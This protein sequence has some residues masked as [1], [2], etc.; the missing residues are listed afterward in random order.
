[1]LNSYDI[2]IDKRTRKYN[3]IRLP[4]KSCKV[5]KRKIS[6]LTFF[7]ERVSFFTLLLSLLK[8]Y[9]SMRYVVLINEI[10]SI[11]HELVSH[12]KY[13]YCT[14]ISPAPNCCS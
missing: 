10:F 7:G 3:S 12:A 6:H 4:A 13:R 8:I 2:Y 11:F 14:G 5:F 1:M 9:I